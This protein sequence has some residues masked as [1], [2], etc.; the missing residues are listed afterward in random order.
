MVI[1]IFVRPKTGVPDPQAS[2]LQQAIAAH[3]YPVTEAK[4][5]K[6][7]LVTVDEADPGKARQLAEEI[8]TKLLANPVIEEYEVVM[9]Q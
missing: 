8:S 7:F 9:P 5:G 1:E 6:Y 3:G 2:Q 4:R